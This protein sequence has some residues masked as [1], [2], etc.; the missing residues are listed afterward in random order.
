ML[1]IKTISTKLKLGD[2]G[3]WYTSD[4]QHISY[5]S[6]GNESC[7]AVEDHSFWFRH[8][9]NCITSIISAYPPEGTETIFDIGGG[10]GFVS[11]GLENA[12]FNVAMVEPGRTGATNAKRRGLKNV[13]CAT[14]DTAKF[15]AH[16]LP[17]VG[18]FDVIEHI[19]DDLSFLQSIGSLIKKGGRLYVTVPSY[20]SLWSAD[21]VSAGHY[22]RY[23][24]EGI[25]SVL[26]SAGFEIEFSSYFFRFLPV[27][28]Y[29]LRTLPYKAGLSKKEGQ[30]KKAN[31]DHA[32]NGG[33]TNKI[34]NSLLQAEIKN[35]DN[36]R[37]MR[38]GGSCLI[39]AR[40]A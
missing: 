4:N 3:I 30:P 39:V 23:T 37:T 18:L 25:S 2:D 33:F 34:L 17:A 15:N 36:K 29:L 35:I 21:D 31:R 1:D 14:T 26:K 6:D 40:N 20:M 7:F 24:V 10:N 8:R 38:F 12:G 28:I 22:R 11:F 13:I 16:S 32:V 27:P 9:N 19:E 5:P